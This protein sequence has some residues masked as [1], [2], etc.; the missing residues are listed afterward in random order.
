MPMVTAFNLH[1]DDPLPEI[2]EAVKR[3]LTSMPELEINDFEVDLVPMFKPDGFHGT[4]TRINVD[5][6]VKP[7]RSKASLQVLATRVAK[8]F[9][10]VVGADRKVKVVI[11]PYEVEASGWVSF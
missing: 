6:W 10:D 9:Q 7:V 2:E 1:A 11:K 8:A 3:A 5:L 4:V